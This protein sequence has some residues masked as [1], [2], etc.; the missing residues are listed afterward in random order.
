M[1]KAFWIVLG[2]AALISTASFSSSASAQSCNTLRQACLMKDSPAS[3]ARAIASASGPSAAAAVVASCSA[4]AVASTRAVAAL[5]RAA[6]SCAGPACS[7]SNSGWKVSVSARRSGTS[8]PDMSNA[9][10]Y[11]PGIP[12][13]LPS[14]SCS[15]WRCRCP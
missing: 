9:A 14:G 4:A 15:G 7:R 6:R 3:R 8:A 13:L 5:V 11:L 10:R 1:T 2:F 12:W